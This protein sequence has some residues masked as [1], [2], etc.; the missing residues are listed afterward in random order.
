MY[1]F[2]HIKSLLLVMLVRHW[3]I[4]VRTFSLYSRPTFRGLVMLKWALTVSLGRA[5]D[6][7]SKDSDLSL[8]VV[9]LL[10][11]HC[12]WREML[13]LSKLV[14]SP[15]CK[16]DKILRKKQTL[17]GNWS[18]FRYWITMLLANNNSLTG[19]TEWKGKKEHRGRG[20]NLEV[21]NF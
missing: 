21:W 12:W 14:P 5:L 13:S 9:P 4:C 19:F 16:N 7:L 15:L 17:N 2:K 6:T 18:K 11:N 8:V 10:W 3:V 1:Q 20:L